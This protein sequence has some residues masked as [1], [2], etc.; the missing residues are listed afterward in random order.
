MTPAAGPPGF[1]I[2]PIAPQDDA[3]VAA[4]IRSVMPEFGACG[5]GY[6]IHD[7]EVAGMF[8]AYQAPRSR[9]FVLVRSGEVVG[10]AGVAPLAGGASGTCE[11]RKMYLLPQARGMG[12]GERLLRLCLDT[13]RGFAFDTCYLETTSKMLQAQ[14]LY[15][16][17]GFRPLPAPRGATGHF[18]CDQ[19]FE[20]SLL[21]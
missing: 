20:K 15:R 11:L 8:Q 12:Q 18:G 9:Y 7:A 1:E 17:L 19:W 21:I 6:A 3:A 2:R 13:A 16:K 14:S 5:A 4:I 10:G